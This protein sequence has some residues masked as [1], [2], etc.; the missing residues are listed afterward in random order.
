MSSDSAPYV[1]T[2]DGPANLIGDEFG[3]QMSRDTVK[4][5][6]LRG[7]LRAVN[8]DEFGLHGTINMYAKSD[9]RE[10]FLA[11]MG[12]GAMAMSKNT[13]LFYELA[14]ETIEVR[15][16]T[17]HR[18]RALKNINEVVHAGDLGGFVE[19][20]ANLDASCGAWVFDDARVFGDALVYGCAYVYDSACVYGNACVFGDARVYGN[21]RIHGDIEICEGNHDCCCS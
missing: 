13:G 12:G 16:H 11:Y 15:G 14:D 3:Y 1:Y 19:S 20:T 10:W 5:A 7:E 4:K 21:A 2:Y 8:R 9:V 6:T 18:I 17:L